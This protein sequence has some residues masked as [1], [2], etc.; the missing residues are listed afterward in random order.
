L[1]FQDSD[2]QTRGDIWWLAIGRDRTPR[3]YLRTPFNETAPRLSPDGRYVAYQ[4]DETGQN[5]VYVRPF[6]EGGTTSPV[7]TEGGIE[8]VWAA[9]GRQLFYRKGGKVMMVDVQV[10]STFTAGH[11][12]V[13]FEEPDYAFPFFGT[14][15]VSQDGRFLFVEPGARWEAAADLH[16]VLNWHEELKARVP[17]K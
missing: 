1:I 9:N 2:P 10:G 5:E 15:D 17:T 6:P 13:L 16:L 12:R 7:S 11:P 8:P 14:Y 3:P 4:S